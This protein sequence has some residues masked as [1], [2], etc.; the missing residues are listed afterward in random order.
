MKQGIGIAQFYDKNFKV[1]KFTD[2]WLNLVGMPEQKGS[3]FIWANSGNGK[4]VFASK[5]AKYLS[6]FGR[7]AYN[8]LEEGLSESLKRAF[9][10]AGITTNDS[11]TLL[12]KESMTDLKERLRKKKAPKF[13]IIDSFQYSSLTK[14]S[15]K[16]LL[17]EF[18]NKLFIFISHADGKKP[19]GRTA[20][21]VHYDSNVKIWIEGFKAY[22]K[23]R[24]GG[25]EPLTIWQEGAEQ[26]WINT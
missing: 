17:N 6:N 20:N 15:Y 3:W 26:Y 2:E 25:G 11:I 12:D 22:A 1:L 13:I 10:L 21:T 8:S 24:Y 18:D 14:D 9:K 5:L 4:T 23:S 16:A 7:V 19:S